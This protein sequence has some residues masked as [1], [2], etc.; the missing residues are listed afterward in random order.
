MSGTKG[1]RQGQTGTNVPSTKRVIGG[2]QTGTD[3][4]PP[5]YSRGSPKLPDR[6][7]STRKTLEPVC[8]PRVKL[9]R[10]RIVLRW[11]TTLEVLLFYLFAP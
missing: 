8:S 4:L 6:T 11:V 10:E 7:I 3:G 2:G 1:D 9:V 5:F